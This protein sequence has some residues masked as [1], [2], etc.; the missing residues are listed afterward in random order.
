M[1][2]VCDSERVRGLVR[3]EVWFLCIDCMSGVCVCVCVEG[4]QVGLE[5]ESGFPVV[6]ACVVC[7]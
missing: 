2:G 4:F 7:V 1:F 5:V 6:S 3:G